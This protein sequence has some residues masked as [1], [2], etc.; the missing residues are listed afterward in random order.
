MLAGVLLAVLPLAGVR[1]DTPPERLAAMLPG[2]FPAASLG[3]AAVG[4]EMGV[5]IV[6]CTEA[7][8]HLGLQ[9]D[10]LILAV[11]G[12]ALGTRVWEPPPADSLTL[13][14]WRRLPWK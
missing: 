10:D 14:V 4:G 2:L 3:D 8:R 11:G 1:A 6:A 7:Q 9:Q 5:R 13:T 12:R